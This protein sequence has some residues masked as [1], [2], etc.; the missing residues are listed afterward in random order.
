MNGGLRPRTSKYNGLEANAPDADPLTE[1]RDHEPP[2][3]DVTVR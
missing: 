1:T 2:G 3:E